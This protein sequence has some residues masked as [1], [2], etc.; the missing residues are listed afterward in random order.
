MITYRLGERTENHAV[1]GQLLLVRGAHRH[2][3]EHRI[4]RHTRQALA[5][6]QRH[7]ELVVGLQ[8]LGIHL[9]QTLG[10]ILILRARRRVVADALIIN[11]LILYM[12][13]ARFLHRL[14]MPKRL[15]P[16]VE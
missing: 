16:P 1:L 2:A 15:E 3:V 5:L 10:P 14:P 4:H 12:R 6:V 13:P 7:A 11:R 9:I 8:Q